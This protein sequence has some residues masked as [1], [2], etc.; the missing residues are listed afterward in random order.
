MAERAPRDR[1]VQSYNPALDPMR[2]V[3]KKS[4]NDALH[5]AINKVH[6]SGY[7]HT[8]QCPPKS[9]TAGLRQVSEATITAQSG[10]TT[11]KNLGGRQRKKK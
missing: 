10:P 8:Y 7:S 3:S 2:R 1:K 5:V 4:R 11:G 6:N 9:Y